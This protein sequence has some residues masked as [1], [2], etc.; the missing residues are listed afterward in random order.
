MSLY[1][2]R[3]LKNYLGSFFPMFFSDVLLTVHV[4]F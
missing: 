3:V 2:N 1:N 4:D